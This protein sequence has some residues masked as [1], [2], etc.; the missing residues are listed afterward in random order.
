MEGGGGR[1]SQG[2]QQLGYLITGAGQRVTHGARGERRDSSAP[3][4][5]RSRDGP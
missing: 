5:R 3:H 2:G 1:A 4:P